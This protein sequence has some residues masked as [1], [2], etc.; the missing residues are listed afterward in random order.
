MNE[1]ARPGVS[2][3]IC[4]VGHQ[5]VNFVHLQQTHR[6]SVHRQTVTLTSAGG[7]T[8]A[9][10]SAEGSELDG[11]RV[12]DVTRRRVLPVSMSILEAW[13]LKPWSADWQQVISAPAGRH[14]CI[15][16]SVHEQVKRACTQQSDQSSLFTPRCGHLLRASH[17]S[18]SRGR[19][20]MLAVICT[21][22]MRFIDHATRVSVCRQLALHIL[23]CRM[24]ACI[25]AVISFSGFTPCGLSA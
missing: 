4:F 13:Q 19:K 23:A 9:C 10:L 14:A 15:G 21:P 8:S 24:M 22:A 1:A 11:G 12:V 18:V 20:V 17:G 6:D 25:S 16:R 5:C 2:V 3:S 7:S